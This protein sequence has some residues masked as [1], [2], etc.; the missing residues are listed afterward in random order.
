MKIQG[1]FWNCVR[2]QGIGWLIDNQF[3]H[4][5]HMYNWHNENTLI[6]IFINVL[7]MRKY[8]LS[9]QNSNPNCCHQTSSQASFCHR[10]YKDIFYFSPL[11]RRL[12]SLNRNESIPLNRNFMRVEIFFQQF[13]Q[14]FNSFFISQKRMNAPLWK[15]LMR[16]NLQFKFSLLHYRSP[17]ELCNGVGSEHSS[18]VSVLRR[19]LSSPWTL[20]MPSSSTPCRFH[21]P[22][23][24]R[25]IVWRMRAILRDYLE[26]LKMTMTYLQF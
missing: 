16:M 10:S 5:T 3:V 25:D 21:H 24:P 7:D 20:L 19:S 22:C 9:I 1:G 6:E 2:I 12:I 18:F 8:W 23:D 14:S 26:R 15:H 4:K 13:F 11:R 17:I